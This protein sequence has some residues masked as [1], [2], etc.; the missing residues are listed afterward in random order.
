MEINFKS[1]DK[2]FDT[3]NGRSY[4]VIKVGIDELGGY[5]CV[6]CVGEDGVVVGFD[7]TRLS[8]GDPPVSCLFHSSFTDAQVIFFCG[9]HC[10]SISCICNRYDQAQG[11]QVPRAP[12][13]DGCD[14]YSTEV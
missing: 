3:L 5:P 4:T 9:P 10:K 6:D 13:H 1:G 11:N 7:P 2:V 12:I 8:I 14:C